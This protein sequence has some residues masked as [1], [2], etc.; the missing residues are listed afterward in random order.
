MHLHL[1]EQP[2][3][4]LP[5]PLLMYLTINLLAQFRLVDF[6]LRCCCCCCC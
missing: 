4:P 6:R 5:P 1:Q 3:F 2:P